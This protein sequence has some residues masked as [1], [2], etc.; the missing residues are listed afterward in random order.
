MVAG[1]D[2]NQVI[3]LESETSVRED[4]P[5][6]NLGKRIETSDYRSITMTD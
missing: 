5:E 1:E 2:I 6:I 3:R 4:E